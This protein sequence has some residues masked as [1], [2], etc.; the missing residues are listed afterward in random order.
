MLE[1]PCKFF[2]KISEIIE[3]ALFFG[4]VKDP[5]LEAAADFVMSS[6]ADSITWSTPSA[7]SSSRTA[8]RASRISSRRR[9][10]RRRS[11]R[12]ASATSCW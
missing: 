8:Q 11:S 9:R 12:S 1:L 6:S 7:I 5:R 4:A 10:C 2:L 3:S